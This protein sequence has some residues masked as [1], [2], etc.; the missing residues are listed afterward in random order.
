MASDYAGKS[1]EKLLTEIERLSRGASPGEALSPF[2]YFLA[3]LSR[4]AD[5]RSDKLLQVTRNL[6]WLTVGLL[7]VTFLLFGL[8]VV[9][10][11]TG[12]SRT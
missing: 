12:G 8:E 6:V 7:V 1:T 2:G 9:E 11:W 10:D 4:D 3:K 5:A